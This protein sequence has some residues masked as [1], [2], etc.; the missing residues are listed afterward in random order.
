[1]QQVLDFTA[2]VEN[3]Q[4]S[5]AILQSNKTKINNQCQIVLDAL[6]SGQKLT[7][8]DAMLQLG[9]G[10]LRRRVKDLIDTAGI[11]IKKETL[12]GGFRAYYLDKN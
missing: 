10:D 8:K 12:P 11:D 3:N 5:N 7:V 9:V 6:R 4:E 2:R 1:M